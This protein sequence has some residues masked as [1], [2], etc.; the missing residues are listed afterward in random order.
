MLG[1]N[2]GISSYQSPYG[3]KALQEKTVNYAASASVKPE[4]EDNEAGKAMGVLASIAAIV[5]GSIIA[6]KNKAGISKVL[7]SV[8]EAAGKVLGKL[9]KNAPAVKEKLGK[10]IAKPL[11]FVKSSG[12]KVV[13][14]AK[15][16]GGKVGSFVKTGGSKVVELV[17]NG[18]AKLGGLVKNLGAKIA[19]K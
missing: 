3:S 10:V 17:K 1:S 15:T 9:T 18:A 4:K 19:K 8:K 12:G 2:L 13:N 16:I 6:V 5:T 7:T 11:A 14:F